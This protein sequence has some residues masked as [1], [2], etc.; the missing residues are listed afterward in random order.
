L[1]Q[2]LEL[3][4]EGIKRAFS[5][6]VEQGRNELM[7]EGVSLEAIN[8]SYHVDLRYVGQS[9][10]L[11]ISW[12]NPRSASEAFHQ[13]HE[14]RYG[15]RLD[16]PVELVNLR[17]T[18][19]AELAKPT[20]VK[21]PSRQLN[22]ALDYAIEGD[23]RVYQREQLR[24]NDVIEGEALIVEQ[25]ATTYLAPCWQCKVDSIGNLILTSY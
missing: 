4:I 8:V 25:V 15:H 11:P 13:T 6:M 10:T 2:L 22:D 9:Y 14:S 5:N 17:V 1:G 19:S 20:L 3:P 24:P 16:L 23:L 12:N 21:L 7:A 18:L